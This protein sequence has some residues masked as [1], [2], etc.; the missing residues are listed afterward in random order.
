MD[1]KVFLR[2]HL[3]PSYVRIADAPGRCLIC[4]QLVLIECVKKCFVQHVC[5]HATFLGTVS[6]TS[7]F[8]WKILYLYIF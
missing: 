7:R 2:T 6:R 3:I 4:R 8:T 1:S 5:L